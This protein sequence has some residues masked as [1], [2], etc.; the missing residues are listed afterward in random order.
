MRGGRPRRSAIHQFRGPDPNRT[1]RKMALGRSSPCR[2]RTETWWEMGNGDMRTPDGR[3]HAASTRGDSGDPPV[4]R[5]RLDLPGRRRSGHRAPR[6]PHEGAP[7]HSRTCNDEQSQ[8]GC[9][10]L[11]SRAATPS[12][13]R[14]GVRSHASIARVR[15]GW[16]AA[17]RRAGRR[18]VARGPSR[19]GRPRPA[20]VLVERA[21]YAPEHHGGAEHDSRR[22]A[23]AGVLFGQRSSRR[24]MAIRIR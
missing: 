11:S 4:A 14:G 24:S 1:P 20:R 21:L 3:G 7:A 18:P 16:P 19:A 23:R 12:R 15:G 22:V 9:S 5:S 17:D 8:A 13:L 2:G 10:A 6:R